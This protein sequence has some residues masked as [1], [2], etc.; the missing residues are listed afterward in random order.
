FWS[1]NIMA[2]LVFSTTYSKRSRVEAMLYLA[3]QGDC[4]NFIQE[5]SYSEGGTLVPQFYANTWS[6]YYVFRKGTDIPGDFQN[7]ESVEES[8]KNTITP[9]LIPNY[10]LF[11][12]DEDIDQRIQYIQEFAD[13]EYMTTIE[14][15]WFDQLLH[16]LNDKNS[17]EKIRIYRMKKR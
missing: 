12:N 15:G 3:N 9:R 8:T 16:R 17:L 11:Y 13:L 1:I 2:L 4:K 14:P 7:M 10:I 6:W 5:F